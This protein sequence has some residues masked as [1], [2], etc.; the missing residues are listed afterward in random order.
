M[1]YDNSRLLSHNLIFNF[2][3]GN[4]GG[5]K[6]FNAKKWAINDF[7]KNKKQ[8]VYVRRYKT[9]MED[10][11]NFFADIIKEGLFE[12]HEF[13][14]DKKKAY[15]DGEVCGYFIPLSVS[16]RKKS[17]AYPEVNKIIFDEFVIDKTNIRY[18]KN[19]VTVFLELC[20]TIIRKRKDVKVTFLSNALTIANPY[21]IY[22]KLQLNPQRRFNVYRD[23]G[24]C[25]EFFKDQDYINEVLDTP[26]GQLISQTEYGAYAINNEFLLDNE[27]FITSKTADAEHT[28][29]L[30]WNNTMFGIWYDSKQD[31]MFCSSKYDKTNK[32]VFALTPEDMREGFTEYKTAKNF[33]IVKMVKTYFGNGKMYFENQAI[34]NQWYDFYSIM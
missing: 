24:I 15:I 7:L 10:M 22:F 8:F 28:L 19:E 21:F 5:G 33:G 25:V 3:V 26:F 30:A 34:K 9:E 14:A 12:G 1:W 13:K 18:L 17:T 11:G 31:V 6:T 32:L 27:H 23:K 16:Q 2:V 4:R 20:S 29:S